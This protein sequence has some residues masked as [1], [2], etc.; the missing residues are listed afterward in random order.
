[1]RRARRTHVLTQHLSSASSK[2][3]AGEI[4]QSAARQADSNS[5]VLVLHAGFP[6]S[7]V[8]QAAQSFASAL[9][10]R[11]GKVSVSTL[12]LWSP[13]LLDQSNYNKDHVAAKMRLISGEGNDADRQTFSSVEDMAMQLVEAD[14]LVVSTPMWNYS[15][16]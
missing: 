7:L 16:P 14:I 5:R 9:S 8:T 13:G 3:F 4:E 15:M 2:M 10:E 11:D 12:D 1:M 6:D